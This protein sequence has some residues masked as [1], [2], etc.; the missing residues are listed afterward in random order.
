MFLKG[1]GKQ[2][3]SNLLIQCKNFFFFSPKLNRYIFHSHAE[4]VWNACKQI[5]IKFDQQKLP[6]PP[7][8]EVY[9]YKLY[10]TL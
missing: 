6:P 7:Q 9:T 8:F 4:T 1:K 5:N 2:T 3:F 10:Q